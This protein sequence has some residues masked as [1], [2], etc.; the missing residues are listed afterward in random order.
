M[1]ERLTEKFLETLKP[2]ELIYAEIA[3]SGAMGNAG[4]VM[5]Y[6]YRNNE[7]KLYETNC[8]DNE[9]EFSN[10]FLFLQRINN[11]LV[12]LDG[13]FGNTVYAK[14][15][16]CLKVDKEN[17]SFIYE[18]NGKKFDIFTSVVGVYDHVYEQIEE[19][20]SLAKKD[21]DK[22]QK[23]NKELID[24]GYLAITVNDYKKALSYIRYKNWLGY[25]YPEGYLAEGKWSLFK[26][27]MRYAEDKLGRV[28][29]VMAAGEALL[30]NC[31]KDP[32]VTDILAKT[33][34]I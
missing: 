13:G 4:G 2:S 23:L 25:S 33:D 5:F 22:Y 24:S 7:L 18:R 3:S 26:Y 17:G 30:K 19:V 12:E 16:S 10:S 20:T 28:K 1:S 34:E 8:Y 6:V 32:H 15:G 29:F 11:E 9:N 14:I 21:W 31:V 27:H